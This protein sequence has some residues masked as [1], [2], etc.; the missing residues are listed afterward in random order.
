MTL[1]AL[2]LPDTIREVKVPSDVILGC[3]AEV[4]VPATTDVPALVAY[5]A[6]A[7]V[8]VTLV[9]GIAVNP[10]PLPVNTPVFAVILTAV[11]VPFTPKPVNVPVEVMF[12]CAAVV[13]VPC[14]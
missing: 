6:L 10:E 13:N 2:M 8:P 4:T 3:A 12:G 7:T 14:T 1:E 9:P 11:T 5:A